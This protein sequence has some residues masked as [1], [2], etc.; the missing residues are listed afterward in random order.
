MKSILVVANT[1]AEVAPLWEV[2][3]SV[4]ARPRYARSVTE[5]L[6]QLE[7]EPPTLLITTQQLPDGDGISLVERARELA[8]WLQEVMICEPSAQASL[9]EALELGAIRS[10]CKPLSKEDL[11]ALINTLLCARSGLLSSHEEFSLLDILQIFHAT[12]RSV[13]VAVRG[14]TPGVIHVRDGEVIHAVCDGQSGEAALVLLLASRTTSARS[15][16]LITTPRTIHAPFHQLMM[17]LVNPKA[18][19]PSDGSS[20]GSSGHSRDD[21]QRHPAR[22]APTNPT[23][24]NPAAAPNSRVFRMPTWRA[25]ASA[26]SAPLDPERPTQPPPALS[27]GAG[28]VRNTQPTKPR[29]LAPFPKAEDHGL[30]DEFE[31]E[32]DPDGIDADDFDWADPLLDCQDITDAHT[33]AH[34]TDDLASPPLPSHGD[35][36]PRTSLT[37][38][39]PTINPEPATEPATEPAPALS[40]Q[41][42]AI[43]DVLAQHRQDIPGCVAAACV[44]LRANA[45]IGASTPQPHEDI[46]RAMI[47]VVSHYF[48]GD[49]IK[50]ATQKLGAALSGAEDDTNREVLLF[51]DTFLHL[52]Y[53]CQADAERA[54]VYFCRLN[55]NI[56]LLMSRARQRARDI[57]QMLRTSQAA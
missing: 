53:R 3:R 5:A 17:R 12:R 41:D 19:A 49:T 38:C 33:D 47:P 10:L 8:P 23:S 30:L 6:E 32:L 26:D 29:A 7:A 43:D 50:R 25:A 40:S 35:I 37:P 11:S 42:P 27:N 57:D 31:V 18:S 1:K 20:D 34:V 14:A 45:L 24:P 2:L 48:Q 4:D 15:T 21:L 22:S 16:P 52:M 46:I 55:P 39:V 28:F 44:D 54:V 36:T 51:S 9:A 13:T 56:G